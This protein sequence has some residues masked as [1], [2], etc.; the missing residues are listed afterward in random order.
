M[1]RMVPLPQTGKT[2]PLVLPQ[3]HTYIRHARLRLI[4]AAGRIPP[5]RG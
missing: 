1:L 2:E 5:Y 3:S 4:K